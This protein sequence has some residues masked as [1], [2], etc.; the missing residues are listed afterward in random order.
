MSRSK[1]K[2]G[3]A[4]KRL[5]GRQTWDIKPVE[6]VV[7]NKKKAKPGRKA[8]HKGRQYDAGLYFLY[9][10][11]PL[12]SSFVPHNAFTSTTTQTQVV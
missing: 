4:L 5:A 12:P 3:M 1:K 8:K 6:R 11:A 10:A 9:D 7:P 2:K